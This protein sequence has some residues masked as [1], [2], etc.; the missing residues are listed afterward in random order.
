[1]V[2]GYVLTDSKHRLVK[3][4]Y[5]PITKQSYGIIDECIL[6]ITNEA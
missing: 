5:T 1:M 2:H 6:Y 3:T 4:W